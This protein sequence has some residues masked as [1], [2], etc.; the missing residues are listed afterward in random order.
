VRE[1]YMLV[2]F[3]LVRTDEQAEYKNNDYLALLPEDIKTFIAMPLYS[4]RAVNRH[5]ETD[6]RAERPGRA[7]HWGRSTGVL[8]SQC[9]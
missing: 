8:R 5:Q 1:Q 2:P 6:M 9:P 3:V 4:V 7:P